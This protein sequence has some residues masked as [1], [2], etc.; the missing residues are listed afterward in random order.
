[1]ESFLDYPQRLTLA[2]IIMKHVVDVYVGTTVLLL[3]LIHAQETE[4][5]LALPSIS[6]EEAWALQ[7]TYF[8]RGCY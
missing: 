1:M 6:T 8:R 3:P 5:S 2:D 4:C 7:A